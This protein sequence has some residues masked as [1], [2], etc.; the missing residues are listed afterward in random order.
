VID[1]V[2][3]VLILILSF[4]GF[5]NGMMRELVGFIGLIGGVFVASRA[6]APVAKIIH[7]S[8]HMG[9]MALLKMLAF[10]LVLA[11]IWGGSSFVATIFT[12]LRAQ[13]HST[14][15]KLLG[16]GIAG[17][18]YFL[19][20]SLIS[21]SLLGSTLVRDN[22]AKGIGTSRLLPTLSRVG[23]TLINLTP[24]ETQRSKTIIKKKSKK[25]T[26]HG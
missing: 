19:I 2:L 7:N 13:P 10:L 16:M 21:A 24:F 20:F 9:D 18:K 25:V 4:K 17:F 26:Q 23:S 5:F 1:I 3:V 11:I 8:I 12:S 15:S 6:A 14:L 22:F